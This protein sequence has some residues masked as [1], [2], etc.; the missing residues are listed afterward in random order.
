MG[1]YW[2]VVNL[3]K[4]ERLE[5]GRKFEEWL[6][7]DDPKALFYLLVKDAH[8]F[9]LSSEDYE[10]IWSD[11]RLYFEKVKEAVKRYKYLGRW[12][13][14]RVIIL[15]DV[16]EYLSLIDECRDITKEVVSELIEVYMNWYER[17][18]M[19]FL[20]EILE[21]FMLFKRLYDEFG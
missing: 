17:Y 12:A 20:K 18:E 14:D 5:L 2:I 16:D 13:G 21:N 8:E 9:L 7:R 4:K 19:D 15:P 1:I 6:W 10:L 11:I 3:D